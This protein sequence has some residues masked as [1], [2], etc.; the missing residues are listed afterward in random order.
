ML[1]ECAEHV[2]QAG[3]LRA[4]CVIQARSS[5]RKPLFFWLP[6]PVLE[7]DLLVR[8]VDV[9]HQDELALGPSVARCG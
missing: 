7:V 1:V 2:H 9:A 5:G 3:P 8:D 6:L 4:G